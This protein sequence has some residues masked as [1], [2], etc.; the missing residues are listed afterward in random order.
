[1]PLQQPD[2]DGLPM[3]AEGR[4]LEAIEDALNEGLRAGTEAV[5]AVVITTSGFREYVYHTLA[6]GSA[7]AIVASVQSR[8]VDHEI[9]LIEEDDPEWDV[10]GQFAG[11]AAS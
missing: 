1:M 7:S 3:S 10:Y 4:T 6:T 5:L 2:P 8:F 11:D 9:Q